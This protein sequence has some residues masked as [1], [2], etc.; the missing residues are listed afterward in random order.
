MEKEIKIAAKL[1]ECRD[2]AKLLF[3]TEYKKKIQPYIDA[4]NNLM[5]AK[6]LKVIPALLLISKTEAYQ[7]SGMTQLMFMTAVVEILEPSV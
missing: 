6:E 1:Y 2:S 3:K 5:K 7:E 4:L